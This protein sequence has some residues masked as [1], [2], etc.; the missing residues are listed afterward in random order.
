MVGAG[1]SGIGAGYHLQTM[2]PNRSYVILEGRDDIGG[3]WDLF[4]YPG[5]RSDSDMHT[6]G[7]RFKPWTAAKAIADGP[8]ILA[9]LRETVAEFGID[10]HIRFGHRVRR[11]EWSTE[12]ATWTVDGARSATARPVTFTCNYLFM[13]SGYYSY[14]EPYDAEIPGRRALRRAGSCTRSSGPRTSTY[15]GKRVVV[16]GS[17]AT[18]MTLVP[19][20]AADAGHVTMLQRSPTYVVSRPSEDVIANGLRRVAAGQAR[21]RPHAP[22]ER[23]PAAVLLRPHAEAAGEGQGAAARAGAQGRSAPTTTSTPTS[24]RA[25]TRGTS[26]CA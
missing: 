20:M 24:R 2:C 12:D 3:T 22:Q 16:I 11:A 21:L 25:T 23:R 13:C 10:R 9:Y 1:I 6:L 14:S 8:S 7:Y 26:A 17:G 19:A 18:A 4:R 5:V 15:A